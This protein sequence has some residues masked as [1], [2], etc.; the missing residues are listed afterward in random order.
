VLVSAWT[1]LLAFRIQKRQSFDP[2][3]SGAVTNICI[4]IDAILEWYA[5]AAESIVSLQIKGLTR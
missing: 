4:D 3:W 2:S 5:S 1:G